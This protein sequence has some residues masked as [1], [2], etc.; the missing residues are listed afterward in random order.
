MSV[1][2]GSPRCCTT[3]PPTLPCLCSGVHL[4]AVP[5]I[6]QHV[7]VCVQGFT[8]LLYYAS[9]NIA[10]SVFRGSPHCCTTHPPTCSCLC[11]GVHLAAV[12]CIH[13]HCHVCVQGFT[14]LLY[15][16]STN[17]VMSVFRGSPRC[18]TTHPPTLSCLCSGVHLAAVPRIHQHCHV[19]VQGFTS[20][21]YHASTNI[22]MSVFRG[23][24]HC[25]TTHPPTLSYLCSGVHL[26]AV[27][28][29]HQHCH[30]CVQGFTSL[31]YQASTNI[32][33]SVF[34]GSPHCCTTH[35]PTLSCLCSGVHLTA[36]PRIHQHCHVCV[37]G[38]TSLLYHASTNIV[39]SVFRGSPHCCTT[40]PPT[41]SC[42]C[43]GV[44]LAAVPRIHQHC[45][46]CVQGFTSLLYHASTN[47]VMSVFRGSPRCCTTHPPTLSCLCSGVHLA[48]VPGIHQH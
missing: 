34:R 6:H 19:C 36:V 12:L 37:Q 17:I 25:C 32:A 47:I 14:S 18:C 33:M 22:V 1:F 35:P 41:L 3:H 20:L 44:H 11:S 16:A 46:V 13:Q 8:S 48:A 30:V 5:G 40:H 39:M 29:I 27:P 23:S 31:L 38:F 9:T 42:L 24:P 45:H 2:R 28:G 4:T 15:H 10:M 21:L 26:A 7:H 43:S